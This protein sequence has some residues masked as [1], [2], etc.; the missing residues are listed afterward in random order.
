MS[1]LDLLGGNQGPFNALHFE[2][3]ISLGDGLSEGSE[4][5]VK[6]AFAECDGLEVSVEVKSMREG[7]QNGTHVRLPGPLSFGNVTLKRGMTRSSKS[8]W[9][10]ILG[11]SPGASIDLAIVAINLDEPQY[12][13]TLYNAIPVK[14]KAPSL[15][16][17]EGVVAIEE[18]QLS[19]E[20]MEID[21][22]SSLG[23]MLGDALGG[24]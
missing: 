17:R 4:P 3:R 23:D 19:F 15:N 11:Y 22:G 16:A 9:K 5:L 8:L 12:T 20:R 10:W 18:L 14:L 6:A 2:V 21:F 1:F 24:D 13:V 7:G